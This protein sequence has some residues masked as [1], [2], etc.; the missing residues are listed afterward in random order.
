MGGLG[1]PLETMVMLRIKKIH[2]LIFHKT[3]QASFLAHFWSL[4][5]KSENS[6]RVVQTNKQ[7]KDISQEDLHFMDPITA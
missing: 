5:K 6:Y 7:A 1:N 2:A 3:W 4:C